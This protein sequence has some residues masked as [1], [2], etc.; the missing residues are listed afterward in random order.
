MEAHMCEE[1]LCPKAH[2]PLLEV[3]FIHNKEVSK[4]DHRR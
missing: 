1:H 2:V 3:D 4:G